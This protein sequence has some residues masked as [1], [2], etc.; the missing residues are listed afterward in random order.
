MPIMAWNSSPC[1]PVPTWIGLAPARMLNPGA[2]TSG[3]MMS[4]AT[5]S[6]PRELKEAN[7]FGTT[8]ESSPAYLAMLWVK[9]TVT[10][11]GLATR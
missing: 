7:T 6:G 10:L 5:G 4:I 1:A 2:V 11:P 9:L 8:R 3:L